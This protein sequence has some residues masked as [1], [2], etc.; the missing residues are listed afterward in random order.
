MMDFNV[1]LSIM[2]LGTNSKCNYVECHYAESR[3]LFI[4]MLSVVV[5]N[6]IM[7]SIV[8]AI[9]VVKNKSIEAKRTSLLL[10]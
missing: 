5:L 6:V 3:V 7:L 2:T 8:A 1:T 9:S 4:V 10:F